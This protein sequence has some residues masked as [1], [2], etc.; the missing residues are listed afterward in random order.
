M[1]R[2]FLLFLAATACTDPDVE[3]PTEVLGPQG[4]QVG[5]EGAFGCVVSAVTAID[6]PDA[7]IDDLAL[8]ASE[9]LGGLDGAFTG[10]ADT[11]D[12]VV[13][14]PFELDVDD[15]SSL[16]ALW[17]ETG[18]PD[19]EPSDSC[20]SYLAVNADL[21]IDADTV[22]TAAF[23]GQVTVSSTAT[24]L[25]ASVALDDASGTLAPQFHDPA[26]LDTTGWTLR[27]EATID[28]WE[29]FIG[30]SGCGSDGACTPSPDAEDAELVFEAAKP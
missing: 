1:T 2:L 26:T 7:P 16:E 19:G 15:L 6:D 24:T 21:S 3:D 14:D 10:T 12:G 4:I 30:F 28:G 29:G 18:G 17:I 27:A 11:W 8:S 23:E 22:F 5:D 20:T 9:A 13:V 25:W